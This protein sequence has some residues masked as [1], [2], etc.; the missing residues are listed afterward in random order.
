MSETNEI[1]RNGARSVDRVDA[2]TSMS[3]EAVST[4]A[5]LLFTDI[6]STVDVNEQYNKEREA[7]NDY[8]IMLTIKPYCTNILFNTCTEIVIKEGSDET[9]A[10]IGNDG[11][12]DSTLRE[13]G[14]KIKGKNND[15]KVH[16]MVRNTEY[17]K[18]DIGFEYH[19]GLD[20]FNNH[21][22]RNKTYR[23]VNDTLK[24]DATSRETFN[25]ISDVM[26]TP[27][28]TELKRCC[29][30]R[31]ADT[32]MT[33]KHL[34]DKDDI[35]P[36][37]TGEAIS[38]NL[39]E[40]DGW[41][42]FYNTTT[43][44]TK[45]RKG[46]D[47]DISRVINS[48]ANCEFIDMY[49]DRTLFSFVPKYNP[50]RQRLEYN[51]DYVLTYPFDSTVTYKEDVA[52]E[53]NPV[54]KDI[55]L[56]QDGDVN[57]LFV[58]TVEMRSLPNGLDALF[59]RCGAK[60]NLA[61]QDKVYVYFNEN[62]DGGTW[63]KSVHT[64]Q[65][66]GI[67]DINHENKEYYFYITDMTLL[68]EIFCT[69]YLC[70]NDFENDDT[71]GPWDYVRDYFYEEYNGSD[72]PEENFIE[73]PD[74]GEHD[75]TTGLTNIP[76]ESDAYVKVG[77][78]KYVLFNHDRNMSYNEEQHDARMFIRAIINNAFTNNDN[79][80]SNSDVNTSMNGLWSDYITVRFVKTNGVY[81]CSYYVRKFKQIKAADGG[82]LNRERYPL[83]FSD[84]I[85][86]DKVTQCVYTDTIN[87][88][89]M[90]D[91]LGRDLSEIF[92]TI[93]KANR[94]YKKWYGAESGETTDNNTFND[95][96]IEY[97][98]CF[99]PVTCGFELS[100]L[101]NDVASTRQT[102]ADLFDVTMINHMS[103]ST[104]IPSSPSEDHFD[105]DDITIDDE[106]FYG[107]VVEFCPWT[108]SETVISDVCFRF[109]TGQRE[110][111][112]YSSLQFKFDEIVSDDYDTEGFSVETYEVNNAVER[113]E[114]YYYKAHYRIP[115]TDLSSVRQAS[116]PY[117]SV[118]DAKPV[119]L[120]GVYLKVTTSQKHK[121]LNGNGNKVLLRDTT[122]DDTPE[123][124]LD[125]VYIVDDFTFIMKTIS[126]EQSVY[127]DWI[128]I[129][130]NIIDNKYTLRAENMDIPKHAIKLGVNDYL[131]RDTVKTV[132]LEN[133]DS[134]C[135]GYVFANK[136]LYVD[137]CFNFYLKRQDPYGV[138]GLYFDGSDAQITCNG[139]TGCKMSTID[140]WFIG[141]TAGEGTVESPYDYND[142]DY[143]S[144]C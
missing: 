89:G 77:N 50:H 88:T 20:I 41:F 49:P 19:P 11:V 43:I 45:D 31:A 55:E 102:R 139:T 144:Q 13:L 98:H 105:T 15:V 68:E 86:G 136:A 143:A 42:G 51:W 142:T 37:Y 91:N 127:R 18:E 92:L 118:I 126:K 26:R 73:Y 112:T 115:L 58:I 132:G 52:G 133:S 70:D 93:V 30:K 28:G 62:E 44:P 9:D 72:I 59:F 128:A 90:K 99:G 113:P 110:C 36:F 69:P 84:T 64:Y 22:L 34:Y 76:S 138:N 54:T 79:Y 135:S 65:V 75:I 57:G 53:E 48:K 32:T 130:K 85:Y 97:S 17:S 95:P 74:N 67:G 40:R 6:K 87:T 122:D 108:C 33:T 10:V 83:A 100:K 124:W 101:K 46:V 123:W 116:H 96:D 131:W 38:E 119:Q 134:E 63:H 104:T 82:E 94:G 81:D 60:H 103:D 29:R 61:P 5:N 1:L 120:D 7:C 21:I 35:L 129:A 12:D 27:S 114:G 56:V 109:N 125:V 4:T 71:Y 117:L 106:W 137:K 121:L 141:D 107:D 66:A 140:K 3:F 47:M 39:K 24:S 14:D 78:K 111:G 80:T 8:R 2:N 25:T 16:D 23:T